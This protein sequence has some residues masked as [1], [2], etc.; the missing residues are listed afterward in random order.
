MTERNVKVKA[1]RSDGQAFE[2]EGA[3]WGILSLEGI[4][5]PQFEI[6]QTNRGYGNGSIITGKRKQARDI[7]IVARERNRESNILDRP[8][9]LGF[10]NSNYTFDLYFTYMGVTRIAKGC[11]LQGAK[12]PSGNVFDAQELT[13]SYLHPESDLLGEN[14][15]TTNFTAVNPLWHVTRVYAPNGGTLAFGVINHTTSKVINYL[16]SEDTFIKVRIEATGLVEGINIS[17]GK[18]E[19]HITVTLGAGDIIEVDSEAKTVKLNGEDV[20]PG[21]YTGELL[22]K[23]I[24]TYGDNVVKVTADDEG[25]T[26]YDAQVT[27]IGRYG[28]L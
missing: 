25:N 22:P 24:L 3:D 10:H 11:Q 21:L 5:F 23:L 14:S 18:I 27:Y 16:G 20:A 13:V 1:V 7:D 12:C 17:I 15:D 6:F 26:A 28:G 19:V 4:D 9:A 2:Y 8:I